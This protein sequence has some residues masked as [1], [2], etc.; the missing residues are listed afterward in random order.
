[1]P[2]VNRSATVEE[3]RTMLRESP[4]GA[5][6]QMLPDAAIL[7]ACRACNHTFRRR[8]YDPVVTVLHYLAQAIQREE[9][10]AAT[11]QELWA[12][13]AADFPEVASAAPDD[14]ALTHARARLPV[15][16]LQ[17]LAAQ[18]L[19]DT[20]EDA[21]RWKGLRLL[22]LDGSTVSMPRE[23]AL[24]EH[25]GVHRAR[26]TAVRYPLARFCCLL[27]V[28]TSTIVDYRF[29]P[30][31]TS[32]VA[33]AQE[34]L[35]TLGRKDLVLADRYFAGSP[36]LA[37]LVARG[38]HFLM[39]KNARLIVERLPVV[40]RFGKDDFLVDL[41]VSEPARRKDPT[42]PKSVRV[43][44]FRATW[45]APTGETITEWFVTS[46]VDAKRFKKKALAK[47][48]HQRWRI[49][50]SYLE[51]KQ[52]FHADVLRSKTVDNIEKEF[53][54]HVLAYQLVRRLMAAAAKKHHAQPTQI[55]FLN[56]ARAVVRFSQHM[57]A[58]PAWA[59][60]IYYERLL[61]AIAA[62]TIDVRPGRLEPRALTREC[63]HYPHLR[64][65]RSEWRQQRLQRT[66]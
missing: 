17:T 14:S 6:R 51:F 54:A 50:T 66:V 30:F 27:A 18:A 61:D 5:L 57:A 36:M 65:C 8:L 28:G 47:L 55:S 52:T 63:K 37:R 44:I 31:T 43:R 38:R 32:E 46:L 4:L 62:G 53:A 1:M 35:G 22:A 25:Y 11:W 24:F 40:K 29:G 33:M 60:P 15:S 23:P 45:K 12:P 41:P 39:R 21:D 42:L 19:R 34:L 10:F 49:E 16:V 9:S 58:A 3:I 7:D 26:T 13:L 56:A 48:Y 2:I 64:I 20:E 59:L